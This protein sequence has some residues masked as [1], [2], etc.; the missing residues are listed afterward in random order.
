MD[1]AL[2]NGNLVVFHDVHENITSLTRCKYCTYDDTRPIAGPTHISL[3]SSTHSTRT[4]KTGSLCLAMI[5]A[6]SLGSMP[7]CRLEVS[8]TFDLAICKDEISMFRLVYHTLQMSRVCM[9][10]PHEDLKVCYCGSRCYDLL[11]IFCVEDFLECYCRFI[12]E[13]LCKNGEATCVWY[14]RFLH[15]SKVHFMLFS[16]LPNG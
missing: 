1:S 7:L 15:H 14:S 11:I 3:L 12:R 4:K 16:M 13:M 9:T 8:I 6:T 2:L 5:D 10:R